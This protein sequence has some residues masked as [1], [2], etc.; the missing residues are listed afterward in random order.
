MA[1]GTHHKVVLRNRNG[2]V[3]K[4]DEQEYFLDAAEA[5]GRRPTLRL[6]LWRAHNLRREATRRR[7]GSIPR[8]G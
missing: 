1:T 4:A 8:R 2:L 5:P 3:I 7:S 6:P